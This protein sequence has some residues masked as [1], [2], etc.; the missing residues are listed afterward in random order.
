MTALVMSWVSEGRGGAGGE[1]GRRGGRRGGGEGGGRRGG[2][3]EV[4]VGTTRI[5]QIFSTCKL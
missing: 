4:R 1:E 5:M 2:G 3:E